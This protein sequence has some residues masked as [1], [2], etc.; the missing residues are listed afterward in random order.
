MEQ[1]VVK[2]PTKMLEEWEEK[3]HESEIELTLEDL[4][5]WLEKKVWVKKSVRMVVSRPWEAKPTV[6]NE[7]GEGGGPIKS[8]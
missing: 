3:S 2:L 8:I 7:I 4:A 5:R 1:V 6:N